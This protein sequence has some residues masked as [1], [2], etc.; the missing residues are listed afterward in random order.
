M[1]FAVTVVVLAYCPSR[2]HAQLPQHGSESVDWEA[3]LKKAREE[4]MA[5]PRSAFWHSQAGT[6]QDALGNFSGAVAELELASKLAPHNSI[7]EYE[8]YAMYKRRGLLSRESLPLRRALERDPENPFGHF[9]L[10]V[11][12]EREKKWRE[13]LKE[14]EMARDLVS[15]VKKGDEYIDRNLNPF[16][17][18]Y[19]RSNVGGAIQRVEALNRS[20]S[21][22][23]H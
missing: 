10:G 1:F 13:S 22:I 19:V 7:Y 23:H 2:G 21:A 15:K 18:D 17:V 4:I 20:E 12:L 11:L 9:E 5:H 14:Y 8:L 3:E 6:A 16:S